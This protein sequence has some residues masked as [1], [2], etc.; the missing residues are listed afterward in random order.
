MAQ[1]ATRSVPHY[2]GIIIYT[3][4]NNDLSRCVELATDNWCRVDLS[5]PNFARGEYCEQNPCRIQN[6]IIGL[7]HFIND[8]LKA[9]LPKV[10]KLLLGRNFN[11]L[12]LFGIGLATVNKFASSLYYKS[13]AGVVRLGSR[14]FQITL[15]QLPKSIC[16]F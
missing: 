9:P 6:L 7:I 2:K 4:Y 13:W 14:C 15:L 8:D 5:H 1:G 12:K 3:R 16:P 11:V 10:D